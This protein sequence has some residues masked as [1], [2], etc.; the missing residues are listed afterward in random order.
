MINRP[1]FDEA[2]I[3]DCLDEGP[4]YEERYF[5]SIIRT[6]D[7]ES[8]YAE[9]RYEVLEYWGTVDASFAREVGMNVPE[10][11]GHLD[12]VLF[13]AWVCGPVII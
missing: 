3:N 7:D 10:E 13:N 11:V 5:E 12:S 8:P 4:N 9:K 6:E 1:F 2:G